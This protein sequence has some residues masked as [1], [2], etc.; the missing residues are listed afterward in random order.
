MK[1]AVLSLIVVT[2]ISAGAVQAEDLLQV[3]QLAQQNDAQLKSAQ[4]QRDSTF[5]VKPQA[6][7][8]LKPSVSVGAGVTGVRS[9]VNH[10]AAGSDLSH[11]ATAD[12]SLNVSHPLYHRD[13]WVLLEQADKQVA[14][15]TSQFAAEQQDLLVRTATAYFDVLSA[16]DTLAF[17]KSENTAIARQLDQSKQRYEVGLIAITSVH[18]AQAAFDQSLADLIIAENTLDNAWESLHEIIMQPVNSL[19]AVAADLPLSPPMPQNM[20]QWSD[21]AQ[22]ENLSI[23]AASYSADIAKDTIKLQDAGDAPTLDLVGSHGVNLSSSKNGSDSQ[24][25]TVGIQFNMP[26]YTG[27]AVSSKTRQARYNYIA[28]QEGLD[29]QRRAVKRQV[30]NAYRGVVASISAVEALKAS[31][32]STQSALEA[33]EAGFDVGTRTMVDVLNAQRDLFRSMS[34]YAKARYNYILSGISLKQ[35]TGTLSENDLQQINSWLK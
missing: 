11:F 2:S 29:K 30:R 31:T 15:A 28:A 3:Y 23:K 34:N 17:A 27:G 1:N 7:A 6:E 13:Y 19:S 26:L 8:L 22:Q 16:Q 5:E 10:S 32:V 12:M 14:Q 20:E 4:A 18:E 24:T 21:K 33:T 9:D 35:A 25:T